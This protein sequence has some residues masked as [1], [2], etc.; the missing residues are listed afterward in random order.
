MPS[1][2]SAK[3]VQQDRRTKAGVKSPGKTTKRAEQTAART[4]DKK[5]ARPGASR[6]L[7]RTSTREVSSAK[8]GGQRSRPGPAGPTHD[9]LYSEARRRNVP[10]RSTMNKAQLARALGR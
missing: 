3:R 10:G 6:V 4:V 5:R 2:S 7:S 9:Q 1:G 8:R